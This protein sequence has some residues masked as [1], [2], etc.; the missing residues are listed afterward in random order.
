MLVPLACCDQRDSCSHYRVTATEEVLS[1]PTM[2][3][4]LRHRHPYSTGPSN[5][6]TGGA[7][8]HDQSKI[9]SCNKVSMPFGFRVYYLFCDHKYPTREIIVERFQEPGCL[10]IVSDLYE[11]HSDLRMI[12]DVSIYWICEMAVLASRRSHRPL[13][14]GRS[15]Q[16]HD[17]RRTWYDR[18]IVPGLPAYVLH[19]DF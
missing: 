16:N 17:K 8:R 5:T 14:V 10:D 3:T 19:C 9:A 12:I 6:A 11:R 15:I 2:F 13:I 18:E 1:R 4:Q 7:R